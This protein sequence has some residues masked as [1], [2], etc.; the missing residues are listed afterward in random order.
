[1]NKNKNTKGKQLR[2]PVSSGFSPKRLALN[3]DPPMISKC[4]L[5]FSNGILSG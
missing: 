5:K 1:M 4:Y 3:F 2:K